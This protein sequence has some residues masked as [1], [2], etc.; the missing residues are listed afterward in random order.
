MDR[1]ADFALNSDTSVESFNQDLNIFMMFKDSIKRIIE[2]NS[3]NMELKKFLDL[4]VAF[5][6]FSLRCYPKNSEYVNQILKDCVFICERQLSKDFPD[7]CQN[8]IVKFLTMPLETMSLTI[9]QMNEYP[10]LMKYLPFTKRRLVAAKICQAVV[11]LKNILS[12]IPLTEQL[13]KFINPLLVTEKDYVDVEPFEFEE[14]QLSVGKL[15]HLV[16]GDSVGTT[17]EL[18]N[19]FKKKFLEGEAKRMKYTLPSLIFALF[20]VIR[21]IAHSEEKI[22]GAKELIKEVKKLIDLLAKEHHELSLRLLLNLALCI[23]E[24]DLEKEVLFLKI[25]KRNLKVFQTV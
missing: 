1:L 12:N 10:N 18:L 7:D 9:L 24:V 8:N 20:K 6:K 23:N 16:I 22:A 11:N 4:E 5:L 2:E 17:L 14:E 13:I 3:A 21:E 25:N 19:L 15:I